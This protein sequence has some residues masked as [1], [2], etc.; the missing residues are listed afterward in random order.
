MSDVGVDGKQSKLEA[1]PNSAQRGSPV[2]EFAEW[3]TPCVGASDQPEIKAKMLPGILNS[4]TSR[5]RGCPTKH[6]SNCLGC[7]PP[8]GHDHRLPNVQ[9][10]IR[11]STVL[12]EDLG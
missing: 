12:V 1:A 3:I 10:E 9:A 2:E 5:A 8:E 4:D 7:G 6:L 11:E